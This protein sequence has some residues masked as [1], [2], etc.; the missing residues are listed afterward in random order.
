MHVHSP[1]FHGQLKKMYSDNF[2]ILNAREGGKNVEKMD[3]KMKKKYFF[4]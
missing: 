4:V 3:K 2:N 1:I